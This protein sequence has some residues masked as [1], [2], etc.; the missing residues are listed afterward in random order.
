M[1]NR[2]AD[3]YNTLDIVFIYPDV[4]SAYLLHQGFLRTGDKGLDYHGNQGL[5]DQLEAL[6]WI[7]RYIH[8]FGGDPDNVTVFG[9]SAG[10][11]LL[12]LSPVKFQ[13]SHLPITEE[14]D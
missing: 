14:I 12:S 13:M 4:N 8:C 5:L 6:R 10:S 9:E 2:F 11:L 7:Q 3:S 1:A